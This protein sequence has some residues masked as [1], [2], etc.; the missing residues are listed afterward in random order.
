MLIELNK[1][2]FIQKTTKSSLN[3]LSSSVISSN[4]GCVQNKIKWTELEHSIL[5]LITILGLMD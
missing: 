1:F 2:E 3:I 4:S 5:S